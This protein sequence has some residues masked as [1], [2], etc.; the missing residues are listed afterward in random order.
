[1]RHLA[2]IPD[3]N[4]RWARRCGL[5]PDQG[6]VRGFLEVTPAL[7]GALWDRGIYA[8]TLWLFSTENWR[9]PGAEVRSLME[10]FIRLLEGLL[11]TALARSVRLQHM[12]R[13]DRLPGAL[14]DV[15][16]TAQ[17]STRDLDGHVLNI[18]LDYGGRDE[19]L[20]LACRLAEKAWRP[21]EVDDERLERLLWDGDRPLPDPDLVIRTSGEL[22]LSGFMPLQSGYS[23]LY[24]SPKLYPDLTVADLEQ[25]IAVYHARC[26]R[27]GQ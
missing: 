24:F 11:P 14:R 6:H 12:G 7:L 22:R 18:A 13:K 21:E 1:L 3:G 10:I 23:E 20:R 25:A 9:R 27:F 4:R 5:P 2:I 15:V 16:E 17:H 26:R 19:I 8:T